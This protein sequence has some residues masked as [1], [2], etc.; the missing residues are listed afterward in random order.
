MLWKCLILGLLVASVLIMSPAITQAQESA[1]IQALATVVSTLQVVGN[2]NLQF[3]TVTPGLNKLVDKSQPG[4]AG[5]WSISGTAGAELAISFALPDS[6][7]LVADTTVGLRINFAG[8][9]ASWD[10]GTGGG[11]LAPAGTLDPNGPTTRRLG[12]SGGLLIWI[13][14]GVI[15]RI[16]Q[17]GGS[18]A[19]DVVLTVAYTGS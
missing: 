15:P 12:F 7:V 18:Y 14:G 17:T 11:Q 3:G 10:D 5:E 8:T 2:N 4:L 13:G 19:A 1:T 6:M 16:S 9:D